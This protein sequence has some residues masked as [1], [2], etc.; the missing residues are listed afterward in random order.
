MGNPHRVIPASERKPRKEMIM[1]TTALWYSSRCRR[2]I[3]QHHELMKDD[4]E[5]LTTEFL[6]EITRCECKR[7]NR[8]GRLARC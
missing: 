1:A 3:R 6:I 4:P 8:H 5:R 7:R 2:D